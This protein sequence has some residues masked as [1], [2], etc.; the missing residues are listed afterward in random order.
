[1]KKQN[2]KQGPMILSILTIAFMLIGGT[3]SVYAQDQEDNPPSNIGYTWVYRGLYSSYSIEMGYGEK[4]EY[5]NKVYWK[6]YA[7]R[8]GH[9]RVI[10]Q[11]DGT[12][13]LEVDWYELGPMPEWL[14]REEVD[15][16]YEVIPEAYR[17]ANLCKQLTGDYNPPSTFDWEIP[18]YD[19]SLEPG[20]QWTML[21]INLGLEDYA[22][23]SCGEE[24][25]DGSLSRT[26]NFINKYPY[27]DI[28]DIKFIEGIGITA[29]GCYNY[30]VTLVPIYSMGTIKPPFIDEPLELYSVTNSAGEI[31]YGNR[32]VSGG[33]D[34]LSD[35]LQTQEKT[36]D[37]FGREVS[38]PQ[39]G[40]VYIRGGKKFVAR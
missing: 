19:Y 32:V 34:T 18:L 22:V 12:C 37:L 26:L 35:K 27:W 9:G 2:I 21:D 13:T 3:S 31:I 36:Y 4:T 39:P 6:F 20:D 5:N 16:V 7:K 15:V 28:K 1:M 17:D 8:S 25:I 14:I 30:M 23:D 33:I 38:D 29:L 11:S 40:T 10:E 24:I